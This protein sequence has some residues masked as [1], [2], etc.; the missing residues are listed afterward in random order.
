[1]KKYQSV[2]DSMELVA[3]RLHEIETELK[4]QFVG[5]HAFGF[6]TSSYETEESSTCDDEYYN[7]YWTEDHYPTPVLDIATYIYGGDYFFTVFPIVLGPEGGISLDVLV[8]PNSRKILYTFK[9][10][11]AIETIGCEEHDDHV[12]VYFKCRSP[13]GL[14]F[15][16]QSLWLH[17]IDDYTIG[18]RVDPFKIH[19]VLVESCPT[20][21]KKF[22]DLQKLGERW[23]FL[24][25]DSEGYNPEKLGFGRFYESSTDYS[26]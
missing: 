25:C 11:Q 18:V 12:F 13:F 22:L 16:K 24:P 7:Q 8:I 21:L 26:M 10:I 14:V 6:K 15:V 4:I 19:T 1:M 17:D 20:G 2:F 23:K 3:N 5:E 9:D